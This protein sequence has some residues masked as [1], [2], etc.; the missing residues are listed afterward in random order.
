MQTRTMTMKSL[1]TL[2]AAALVAAFA[3]H[4]V[5]AEVDA[6]CY[7]EWNASLITLQLGEKCKYLDPAAAAKVKQ[8]QDAR[9]QC[10]QAKATAAEKADLA[11]QMAA[12]QADA[13]NRVAQMQCTADIRKAYDTQVMSLSST[14]RASQ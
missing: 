1:A 6:K 4:P 3:A 10:F 7:N 2:T 5:R 14:P 13:A 8:G 12:A 9:L 11:K